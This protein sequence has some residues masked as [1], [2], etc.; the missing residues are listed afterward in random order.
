MLPW[1]DTVPCHSDTVPQPNSNLT[2]LQSLR[3]GCQKKEKAPLT[4]GSPSSSSMPLQ[5]LGQRKLSSCS[6][7][8]LNNQSWKA[9]RGLEPCGKPDTHA[10]L[11]GESV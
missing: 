11:S 7:S 2:H 9:G 5:N 6:C 3:Q 4:A 8:C 10:G 1:N